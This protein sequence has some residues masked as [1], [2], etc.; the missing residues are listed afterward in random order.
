MRKGPKALPS[1][2]NALEP[3]NE[4]LFKLLKQNYVPSDK[5]F[6]GIFHF[7]INAQCNMNVSEFCD[8][9]RQGYL[10]KYEKLL[11]VPWLNDE[12]LDLT[13]IYVRQYYRFKQ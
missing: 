11:P 8:L 5:T 9:L 4:Y 7:Q 1:L 6:N 2:L 3:E 12:D 10:L 13:S